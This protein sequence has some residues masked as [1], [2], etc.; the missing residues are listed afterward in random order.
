MILWYCGT[1]GNLLYCSNKWLC[2]QL[3]NSR[4]QLEQL[5]AVQVTEQAD[6]VFPGVLIFEHDFPTK[7]QNGKVAIL[8]TECWI[9][10]NLV[11][12]TFFKKPVATDE[13]LG[14]DS[15]FSPQVLRNILL[16][17][18][19]RRLLNCSRQ[20]PDYIKLGFINKFNL[21][22]KLA[23]HSQKFRTTLTTWAWEIYKKKLAEGDL[24]RT[25]EDIQTV[26]RTRPSASDWFRGDDQYDVVLNVQPT[27]NQVLVNKSNK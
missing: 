25:R 23:G 21:E 9:E 8:D 4:A 22:L 27:P 18:Y 20:L 7:N 24:Y 14:P 10:Q 13:V 12:W 26:A 11:L 5:T 3:I 17:E 15:G 16:Q 1:V 2:L 6:S 19:L